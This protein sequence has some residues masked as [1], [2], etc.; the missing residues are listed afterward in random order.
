[1]PSLSIIMK[2]GPIIILYLFI[3][4]LMYFIISDIKE[5]K[6]LADN[7]G[8]NTEDNNNYFLLVVASFEADIPVGKKIPIK[9]VITIGRGNQNDIIIMD[10]FTSHEHAKIINTPKGYV[11]QDLGS[12]NGVYLNDRQINMPTILGPKD[13]VKI[14]G[15]TF[16]FMRWENE[17]Q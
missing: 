6:P 16:Q 10:A 17:V 8:I 9:S 5:K 11:L 14:G 15:V 2:Y 3:F 7:E 1:M 12:L 4:R 13:I